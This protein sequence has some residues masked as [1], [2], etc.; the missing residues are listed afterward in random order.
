[1]KKTYDLRITKIGSDG[2]KW[3]VETSFAHGYY[4]RDYLR[5]IRD[6]AVRRLEIW[7]VEEYPRNLTV[8]VP[9]YGERARPETVWH[10][11][12]YKAVGLKTKDPSR[13]L[14]REQLR[15]MQDRE[16]GAPHRGMP[17]TSDPQWRVVI[18][19]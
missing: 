15:A 1:M 2:R 4:L 5:T 9:G 3:V 14:V 7:C 11:A 17:L 19:S 12:R 18:G 10:R 6:D 16:D 13:S 8:H